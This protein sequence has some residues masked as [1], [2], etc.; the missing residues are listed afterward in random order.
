MIQPGR[1]IA[2][3]R[4]SDVHE[5]GRGSVIKV[6]RPGIPDAWAVTEAEIT[7]AVHR[8]GLPTPEVRGVEVVDGRRSIVFERID[9][10]SLWQEVL[11]GR[12]TI[13]SAAAGQAEIQL[14]IHEASPPDPLQGIAERLSP[15]I[16]AARQLPPEERAEAKR[17]LDSLPGPASLC[18]GDLHPGNILMSGRGPIVIDWFDAAV[19][20]PIADLVRSSLLVRPPV[21]AAELLHLPGSS[22]EVL[23]RLHDAYVERMLADLDVPPFLAR[24]WEAVL[25]V[26]RLSEGAE[27]D[28]SALLALWT[29]RAG[30]RSSPLLDLISAV[31]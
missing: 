7:V 5:F 11:D 23:E 1:L 15:K 22:P 4:T 18:H 19:G 16:E 17:L 25:A 13:S 2:P 26:S 27:P 3:G 12:R 28:D 14:S 20:S 31:R 30:A 6:P 24:C 9:G 8:L 10:S 21:A 29:G